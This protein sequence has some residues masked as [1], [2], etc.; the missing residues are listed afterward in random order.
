MSEACSLL[1]AK[2]S[3]KELLSLLIIHYVYKTNCTSSVK[4]TFTGVLTDFLSFTPPCYKRGL[5][6]TLID[7]AFKINNTWLGFHNHI[8]NLF[9]I[10]RT[11]LYPGHVLDTLLHRYVTKAV[12]GNETGPSTGVEQQELPRHYFKIPYIGYYS[13]VAQQ[14]VRKLSNRFCKPIDIKTVYQRTNNTYKACLVLP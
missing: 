5:V 10:L 1:E 9:A 13:G 3:S 12:E 8:Q 7:R 14:S 11:N 4:K 6:K 2:V